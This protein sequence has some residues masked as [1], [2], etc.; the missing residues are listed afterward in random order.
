MKTLACCILSCIITISCFAQKLDYT[1]AP[2][3]NNKKAAVSLTFDDGIKGQY[4]VALPLLNQ[5][6]YKG[7][8]FMTVKIINDQHISW[9]LVRKAALDGH[10]IAN[11]ALTHPHFTG[12]PLDSIAYECAQSNQL[13]NQYIPSQ[14]VITHAYPFGDGGGNTA[15]DRAIRR[16]VSP[17]FIAARVTRNKPYA[18]NPYDFA[19]TNDDYYNI[20]SLMITDSASFV[21]FGKNTDETIAAG[22]YLCVTYHG[23]ADGWI[24]TPADVFKKHLDE[25]KKREADLWIAPFKNVMQYHK[26]RNSAR[27]TAV[28]TTKKSWKLSLTDT[29]GN[30]QNWDQPLPLTLIQVPEG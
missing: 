7:T 26:E 12:L 6:G 21:D 25:L 11:H 23:V 1:I 3:L 15:G 4:L 20:N 17:Y 22:G 19:K 10:E 16:A 14:K 5:Y 29:L 24:I 8:F 18:Y 30:Q 27:L 9:G 13:F 2:W 28:I